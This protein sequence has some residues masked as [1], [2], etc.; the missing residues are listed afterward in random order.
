MKTAK[1]IKQIPMVFGVDQRLYKLSEPHHQFSYENKKYSEYVIVSA[2]PSPLETYIFL[3]D[4]EGKVIDSS[5]CPGSYK[6][7]LD[8]KKALENAGYELQI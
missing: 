7:G 8:H 6:G 2:L 4:A 5:E 1:F 3:A